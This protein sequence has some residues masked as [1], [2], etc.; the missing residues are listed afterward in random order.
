MPNPA[1]L[2]SR[3]RSAHLE[4]LDD[5]AEMIAYLH[6]HA[7]SVGRTE[8]I[9]IKYMDLEVG[10]VGSPGWNA[11]HHRENIAALTA[12]GVTAISAPIAG[13]TRSQ[14]IEALHQYGEEIIAYR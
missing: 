8:P 1:A 7:A 13:D 9:D 5:L 12:I 10:P 3:R 14:I 2:A 4:T 11:D 6:D